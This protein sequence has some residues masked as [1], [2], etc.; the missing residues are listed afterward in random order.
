LQDKI[1]VNFNKNTRT[2]KRKQEEN[3]KKTGR[4]QEENSKQAT[5]SAKKKNFLARSNLG[6][7]K[8]AKIDVD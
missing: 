3:R 4:K 5:E 1:E 8:E 6:E 2:K 7:K